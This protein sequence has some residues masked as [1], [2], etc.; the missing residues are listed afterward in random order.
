MQDD[1]SPFF[2]A[3]GYDV[4]CDGLTGLVAIKPGNTSGI[5]AAD[6]IAQDREKYEWKHASQ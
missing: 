6:L 1:F 2:E 4:A 3:K 5:T